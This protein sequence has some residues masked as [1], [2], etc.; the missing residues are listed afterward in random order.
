MLLGASDNSHPAWCQQ[1]MMVWL[2]DVNPAVFNAF[3]VGGE[4]GGQR[5]GSA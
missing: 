1:Q 5:T 3:A 2:S 4:R